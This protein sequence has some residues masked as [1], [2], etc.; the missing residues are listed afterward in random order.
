MTVPFGGA[1]KLRS[2]VAGLAIAML[3]ASGCKQDEEASS[4]NPPNLAPRPVQPAPTSN[5]EKDLRKDLASP[6]IKPDGAT[7]TAPPAATP[8]TPQPAGTKTG[9]P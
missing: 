5:V 3:F 8:G 9:T 4:S 2:M 7:T 1:V 6:V